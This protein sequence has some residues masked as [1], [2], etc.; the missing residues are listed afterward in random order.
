MDSNKLL[1]RADAAWFVAE[2]IS[3]YVLPTGQVLASTFTNQNYHR[4]LSTVHPPS[5]SKSASIRWL[6]G[7]T[8][9]TTSSFVY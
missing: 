3:F 4:Y 7:S 9:S 2:R 6:G 5:R 8:K 1:S